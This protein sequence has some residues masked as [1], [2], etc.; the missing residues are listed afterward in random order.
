MQMQTHTHT[1]ALGFIEAEPKIRKA[2]VIGNFSAAVDC[3]LEAG[4]MAEAL[5]L[6]QVIL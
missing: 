6:A 2:L 4:L 5:L 1:H 3:C